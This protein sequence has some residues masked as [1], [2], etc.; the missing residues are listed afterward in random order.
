M[1][2]NEAWRRTACFLKSFSHHDNLFA[3]T[4]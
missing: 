4:A 3:E 1:S 2:A